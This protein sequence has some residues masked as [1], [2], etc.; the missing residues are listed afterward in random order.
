MKTFNKNIALLMVWLLATQ[1]LFAA[2]PAGSI[3]VA[4]AQTDGT[5]TRQSAATNVKGVELSGYYND[6]TS[7]MRAEMIK[8]HKEDMAED[9]TPMQRSPIADLPVVDT[10]LAQR[11]ST[12]RADE[13]IRV[14]IHLDYLPH[15]EVLR[16]TMR[17]FEDE[18][19][20]VEENR[21]SLL[22]ELEANRSR[23]TERDSEDYANMFT[24]TDNQRAAMKALHEQNE[25]VSLQIKESISS[26]LR[27]MIDQSQK[28]IIEE[29]ERLGGVFEF[30][31]IAN[32]TIVAL[33]PPSA[34]EPL[35][36]TPG[37]L[38]MIEDSIMEGHLNIADTST[39]VDP[40][41]TTLT[42]LW[43]AGRDGGIY[44]P[45]ILDSGLDL[46][47]PAM[48]NST[49]PLRENFGSWYLVAGVGSANWDDSFTQDD[50][51]GH[52]THVAGIV[53]SYGSP[54]FTQNLGMAHGI[55]KLVNLK[56]GWRNTSGTASMFWSDKYNLVDR[57]LFNTGA[58]IGGTFADDVDGFNLSYGGSTTLDDTD[59]GRF[60]DSVISTIA[61]TPVTISAGNSGP[62]NTLFSD[63]A[64]SYNAIAVANANDRGTT[65]RNDDIINAG[66]TV[67]PTASNRRK[68]DLAAPGTSISAP[69]HLWE[70]FG[71]D[72]VN[73][74]GTSMAAPMVLGI[75]MDL[76]D[77]GLFDELAL[78]A[79]LINTAQKNLPGMNIESDAD[80]WDPQI[81]WGMVNAF[82]AYF[83][84]F[85]YFIDSVA[86][87]NTDGDYQL[88]R[89]V[90]RDEGAAGEGRDRATMVWNRAATYATAAAPSTY[91]SLTDLNLR[92]YNETN[93]ALL[94]L[95]TDGNDNVH[96]V[97]VPAGSGDTEVVINA[98]AWSTTFANGNATETFALATEDGFTRVDHPS[99]FQGIAIWP[100]SVEPNEVFEVEFWL[101]ND[102][103]IASHANVFEFLGNNGFTL[104]S[105]P[106][107]QNVGSIAS[108]GQS[109]HVNYSIRAPATAVGAVSFA[110]AH[111]HTSYNEPYG[112]F[113][114]NLSTTV[115][116]DN[117]PPNPNPMSFSTFPTADSTSAISMTASF[118]NDVHADPIQYYL[119]YTS[120]PSAGFGGT[121]S[122]W[123]ESRSFVD[124]GLQ[125]N[126]E[127]C[128][129]AW[130]RD[131]ANF[132][133]NTT[134]SAIECVYTHQ[135]V[136]SPVVATSVTSSTIVVQPQGVLNNLTLGLSGL[137]IDETA[138]GL[139]TGWLQSST[140]F[141]LGG[142]AAS[143]THK[144]EAMAR[145]GDGI[146][147]GVSDTTV[148][149][150]LANP[151]AASSLSALSDSAIRVNIQANGNEEAEYEIENTT[152]GD[153]S[154]WISGLS[155]DSTG[156]TCE[157]NYNF[158]A[159][160]RNQDLIETI[161]IPLGTISTLDCSVDTDGDGVE[162]SADNC[163]LISNTDQRDTNGDGYG[164]A[165]DPDL[166]NDGTVNFV[167]ISLFGAV[168]PSSGVG[169][170][171]DFNGDNLVNFVDYVL[172][173]TFFLDPP[174]PSGVAP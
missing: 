146:I 70:G 10:K 101:R 48:A 116:V 127:Y 120:S 159:R 99:Q 79:V 81:G 56:A 6:R 92:L 124:V 98:Y 161:I 51:Q 133:N 33:I 136:P 46:Q 118:A 1:P 117:T 27:G 35:G 152:T 64:V 21:V 76:M 86:P 154:G 82:A 32:N 45:A 110:V 83:H 97:R 130:A 109:N 167:D 68:P 36:K 54:G 41:D 139:S 84:R 13:E 23:D 22:N 67:G 141:S 49:T 100:T 138:N 163:T 135:V 134:P 144:F 105:G 14:L 150:T 106:T 63:P 89:G 31:T 43:D 94:D 42:G 165:C 2:V 77:A 26:Q 145:N 91:Y 93:N 37:I 162:D 111:S 156:L 16:D 112:N 61:D 15:G 65:S 142:L 80:G 20:A 4:N 160:A 5:Q 107:T 126:D 47:H 8:H 66:S 19:N 119:D 113:N 125:T 3:S 40:A 172:F 143:A 147:S 59:G 168:F 72:H 24:M 7:E 75:I 121:D 71:A 131:S 157:T 53:G 38:R 173:S 164:N 88:Y 52:G 57:A 129:R 148:V 11:A 28:P 69:N 50:L 25:A 115:E 166:N 62:S 95:D 34:I 140:Q 151:P 123:Q 122:G 102:S 9:G 73:K 128:Y 171:E 114:W 44:D 149:Y 18:V 153:S 55:E 74:T 170:D 169:L 132:P 58:L 29:I 96:Q 103:E 78:K 137:K 12:A 174:G 30:G 104:V 158:Q 17:V 60:W 155:W 85:D 39:M 90:M 108:G 87:R